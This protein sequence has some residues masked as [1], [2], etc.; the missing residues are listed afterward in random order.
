[1]KN[2]LPL[3]LLLLSISCN[4]VDPQMQAKVDDLSLQ[5]ADAEKALKQAATDETAFISYGILLDE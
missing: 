5:L 3:F 2:L 1:M 4:Q